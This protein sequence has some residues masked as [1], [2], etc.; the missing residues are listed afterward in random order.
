[1]NELFEGLTKT[2]YVI[3]NGIKI[4]YSDFDRPADYY[5]KLRDRTYSGDEYANMCAF[6]DKSTALFDKRWKSAKEVIDLIASEIDIDPEKCGLYLYALK[7]RDGE[8]ESP[9]V[10]KMREWFGK[11]GE[12]VKLKKRI[13][14]LETEVSVLR[15]ALRE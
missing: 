7:Q 6:K 8:F 2:Q 12:K 4:P 10:N 9:L 13:S 5:D 11:S 15:S 1:V 3:Q 14:E